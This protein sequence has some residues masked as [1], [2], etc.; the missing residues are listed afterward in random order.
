MSLSVEGSARRP[1]RALRTLALGALLLAGCATSP[2]ELGRIE[3]LPEGTLPPGK[4]VG[5]P[6]NIQPPPRPL[7]PPR[8][9]YR[10]PRG[11]GPWGPGV[12]GPGFG[13]CLDPFFC[14]PAA[15]GGGAWAGSHGT[16]F[17]FGIRVR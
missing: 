6:V 16:G 7:P 13:P 3:R 2:H 14:V 10:Y 17:G 9:P 8:H 5:P 4:E 11:Y 1:R 15:Y 12:Y